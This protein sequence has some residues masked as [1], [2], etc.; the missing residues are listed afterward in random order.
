MRALSLLDQGIIPSSLQPDYVPFVA[1]VCLLFLS[2]D[3][4]EL[5]ERID[6]RVAIMMD[7]GWMQ[8]VQTLLGTP[9]QE[10]LLRKKLIGYSEIIHYLECENKTPEMYENLV[11]VIQQKTRHYA[12]RQVTFWRML[13]KILKQHFMLPSCAYEIDLATQHNE[14]ATIVQSFLKDA[15]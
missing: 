10:F 4:Q 11:A 12:K 2:R 6:S 15:R 8:E 3:R 13:H 7:Q 1:D 9:W 5:Y 14:I